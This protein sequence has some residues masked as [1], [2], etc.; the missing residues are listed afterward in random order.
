MLVELELSH[1]GSAEIAV[2]LLPSVVELLTL[3]ELLE[4]MVEL[5][6]E[7]T[8]PSPAMQ[9]GGGGAVELASPSVGMTSSERLFG[10]RRAPHT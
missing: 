1:G 4:M 2:L 8:V 3:V 6:D 10:T 5:S 9:A 7:M